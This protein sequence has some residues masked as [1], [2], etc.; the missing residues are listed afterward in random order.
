[1]RLLP[2]IISF[3][4]AVLSTFAQEHE[5]IS[6]SNMNMDQLKGVLSGNW[7]EQITGELKTKL[8]AFKSP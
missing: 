8:D 6:L 1:M 2:I 4:L 7:K 5:T 3:I